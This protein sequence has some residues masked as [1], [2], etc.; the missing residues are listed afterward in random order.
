MV[1]LSVFQ[2]GGA[3]W[4]YIWLAVGKAGKADFVGIYG[5]CAIWGLLWHTAGNA[6]KADLGAEYCLKSVQQ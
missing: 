4:V 3:T 5:G 6:G 2:G 1:Y